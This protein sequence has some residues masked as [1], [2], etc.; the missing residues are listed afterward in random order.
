MASLTRAIAFTKAVGGLKQVLAA[1]L[2]SQKI[3][4]SPYL[5]RYEGELPLDFDLSDL[6]DAPQELSVAEPQFAEIR[7]VID[8]GRRQEVVAQIIGVLRDDYGL[9]DTPIRQNARDSQ[10]CLPTLALGVFVA[11]FCLIAFVCMQ[12]SALV[13]HELEEQAPPLAQTATLLEKDQCWLEPLGAT[14]LRAR[15]TNNQTVIIDSDDL[16]H[17]VLGHAYSP[18]GQVWYKAY[19][20]ALDMPVWV[21][22]SQ[23]RANPACLYIQLLEWSTGAPYEP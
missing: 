22:G 17:S 10:S 18:T 8:D 12:L 13:E 20:P 14:P 3:H 7:V 15:T 23:V 4:E 9:S 5:A 11:L 16:I 19:H 1:I 2:T 21:N 6:L